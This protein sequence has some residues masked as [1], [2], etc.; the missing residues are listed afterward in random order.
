MTNFLSTRLELN[1]FDIL[2]TIDTILVT[3]KLF[4]NGNHDKI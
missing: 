3:R 2:L 1:L 4:T